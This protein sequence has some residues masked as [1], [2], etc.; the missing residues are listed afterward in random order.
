[1]VARPQQCKCGL[2][3]GFP[4]SAH[5]MHSLKPCNKRN[6]VFSAPPCCNLRGRMGTQPPRMPPSCLRAA[7]AF[8]ISGVRRHSPPYPLLPARPR[9]DLPPPSPLPRRAVPAVPAVQ[10]HNDTLLSILLA[11]VTKGTAA[12]NEVVD[13]VGQAAYCSSVACQMQAAATR[14]LLFF[15]SMPG[16]GSPPWQRVRAWWGSWLAACGRRQA[17]LCAGA[18]ACPARLRRLLRIPTPPHRTPRPAVQ[19]GV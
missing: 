11:T 3:C 5:L 17:V 12:C 9:A 2:C 16:A 4:T 19:P 1:M 14:S 6:P 8:A 13:K 10:D 15:R 18:A 7:Q